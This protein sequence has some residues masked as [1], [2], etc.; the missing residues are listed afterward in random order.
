MTD[1]L[2][3]QSYWTTLTD[4]GEGEYNQAQLQ[5]RGVPYSHLVFGDA[6][7]ANV[8]PD[9]SRTTLVNEVHRSPITAIYADP[10]NPSWLCLETVIPA[11]EGGWWIREIG[12]VTS[13]GKLVAIG[14]Y[15]PVYKPKLGQQHGVRSDFKVTLV[16]ETTSSA[17][18]ELVV[19]PSAVYATLASIASA[20]AQHNADPDAHRPATVDAQGFVR[21]AT[22]A[23]AMSRILPRA[24]VVVT[25]SGVDASM[26]QHEEDRGGH[27]KATTALFGFTRLATLVEQS[28]PTTTRQDIAATPM[29]VQA[30]VNALVSA[31][32][33]DS[34]PAHL[35]AADPH[36]QYFND[37]RLG[38]AFAFLLGEHLA[39][40]DPHSQ[41]FNDVRLSAL[42]ASR[43]KAGRARRTYF[44]NF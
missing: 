15:A 6:N 31:M 40:V 20:I 3:P 38:T 34:L 43:D 13:T 32:P 18:P 5:D 7:G 4:L 35:Q 23:Q 1:Q 41:Y 21:L 33:D 2:V 44:S 25:P 27:E 17:H 28:D 10:S 11:T 26:R 12:A 8:E 29:G 37:A 30:V 16:V 42:L 14:S 36:S 9:P 24:D 19:D 22:N 39:E